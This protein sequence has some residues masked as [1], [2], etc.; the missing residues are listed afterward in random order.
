M[1]K[2]SL[3]TAILA[4]VVAMSANA[5]QAEV[6]GTVAVAD[7]DYADTSVGFGID[8]TYYF[9]PVQIKNAPLNEAAFLNRASN[10]SGNIAYSDNDGVEITT[11]GAGIEYYVPNTNFYTGAKIAHTKVDIDHFGSADATSYAAELGYLPTAGLLIAVG[12]VGQDIDGGDND[13][14]P[15]LRAKYVTQVGSYDA[16]FEAATSFGDVD[17]YNLAA[18]LYLDKTLSVGVGYQDNDAEGKNDVFSINAKKFFNQQFSLQGTI[19]FGDDVNTYGIR[20][21]YRF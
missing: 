10:V 7:P 11:F 9:N 12:L 18:D 6:G 20:G 5:Y 2:L 8:G 14:D 16:N 15:T 21:A 17:Y 1:K 3:A 4:S 13:V 19:A